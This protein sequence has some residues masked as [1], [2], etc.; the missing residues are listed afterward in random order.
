MS[1]VVAGGDRIRLLIVS[2]GSLV[3]RNILDS[4]EF[5]EHPR[6]HLFRI[7]GTNSIA[8]SANN[9]RCDECHLM[10]PTASA[11]FAGAMARVLRQ[12]QPHLIL[13]ARDADTEAVWSLLEREPSLPGCMPYGNLRTIR[14]ALDKWQS[15]LF[16]E[17]HG[18]P[19]AASIPA[20]DI[21]SEE[22][23]RDFVQRVGYPLIAKPVQGFAS[24]GVFF[25]RT[26]DEVL[27]FRKQPDY[28]LQEYLGDPAS[29][30]AYF[31]TLEGP[32]PLF[33]EAPGV[34]HH[35]CHVPIGP[36]GELGEIFVLRNHHNF[37]AVTRLE[38]VRHEELAALARR[39]AEAFVSEGGCGPLSIQFR[40][41]RNGAYAAQE[42]NLRTTGS[43]Y[44]RLMM[45]QD[46]LG[47]IV[48]HWLR[49]ENFPFLGDDAG[50]FGLVV[51]KSLA[52]DGFT[53]DGVSALENGMWSGAPSVFPEAYAAR[54]Y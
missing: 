6:R 20:G 16:C 7:A 45:G 46:E 31:R 52:S 2:V 3:G 19:F 23:I 14:Y 47:L 21:T 50:G 11:E 25:V 30:E 10:P 37:G 22:A 15:Y 27:H 5:P 51:A 28:L 29:L 41:G 8:D 39:F 9:F 36:G 12:F 13:C 17:A 32:K 48:R 4:L 38:R 33:S 53:R 43:T 34:S 18:L 42:M 44:A 24:K 54:Q 49:K 40:Q 1:K 35:T 26:W